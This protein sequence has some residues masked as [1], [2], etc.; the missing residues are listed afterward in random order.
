MDMITLQQIEQL[1]RDL[2]LV[3]TTVDR[4]QAQ[5]DGL[6][7]HIQKQHQDRPQSFADLEGIWKGVDWSLDDLKTAEYQVPENLL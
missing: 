3:R 4:L 2:R 6:M 1:Q 7:M 5:V